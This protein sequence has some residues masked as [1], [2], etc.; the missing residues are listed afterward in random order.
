MHSFVRTL[1]RVTALVGGLV[2]LGLVI[3]MTVTIL[4][5]ST[6]LGELTGSYELLE[7]GIAFAIFSFLPITQLYGCTKVR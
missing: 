2:L 5:R 4:G 7:A 3:M 6:G 1:A